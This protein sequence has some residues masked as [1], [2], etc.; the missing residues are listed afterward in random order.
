MT[1]IWALGITV[2][3][4]LTGQYPFE[5]ATNP[6]QLRDFIL[7]RDINFNLVTRQKPR[8][9]LIKM[10]QKDPQK[11]CTLEEIAQDAWVTSDGTEKI[12]FKVDDGMMDD[13][14]EQQKTQGSGS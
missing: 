8:N 9:L 13:R 10:L 6:L 2:F 1:D 12:D 11:R 14:I 3:Y 4:L 7:N 5:D